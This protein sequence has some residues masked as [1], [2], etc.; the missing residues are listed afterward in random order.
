[1]ESSD[2]I[3]AY[4]APTSIN[5]WLSVIEGQTETPGFNGLN[6]ASTVNPIETRSFY[7]IYSAEKVKS[8]CL[9]VFY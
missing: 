1:M 6:V 2:T 9:T 7:W 8:M 3:T 5:D 4:P